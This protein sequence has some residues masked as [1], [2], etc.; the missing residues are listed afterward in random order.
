M[1]AASDDLVARRLQISGHTLFTNELGMHGLL[2]RGALGIFM[3]T[4]LHAAQWKDVKG[5]P[6]RWAARDSSDDG[7]HLETG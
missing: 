7:D 5:C 6:P 1:H 2:E 3:E 4:H